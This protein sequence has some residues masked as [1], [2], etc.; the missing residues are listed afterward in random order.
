M[1]TAGHLMIMPIVLPLAAGAVL[2]LLDERR[3]VVKAVIS[4]VSALALVV[5]AI[6]L[7]RSV[8]NAFASSATTGVYLL[9]NWPAP[10]GIVLVLDRLSALMLVLTSVLALA[11]LAFSLARWHKAGPHFHTLFQFLLM[12]LN[13]AFL[14]GDLFN[15]FV[16]FEVLLAASYGLVLHGSGPLRVKAGLHYIAVNLAASSL[17]LIGV[18]L[19]YGVTGT[20]NMADLAQ[21]IPA[22]P[23][24]DRMLLEAGAAVL[25]VAFLVK[26]GMWPLSFW[27]P[28][29]YSAAAA[30]VA[31]IFVIMTKVGFYILLRLS[32]LLF[33][34][35]AGATAGFGDSWLLFGG[36]A[37]IAFGAIGVLAS[38]AVGRLAGFS[39]LVSS[40]TLLAAIGMADAR[41]TAGALFYMVSST[42]TIGAFFLLIELVERVQDPAAHVLSVTM[43]A[44]RDDMEEPVPE[45][46]EVGVA[47]PGTLAVLGICFAACGLLLAGLPPLSGF[48]GKFALLTAMVRPD[49]VAGGG[50][51]AGSTWILVALLI[52]S[53][54]CALIATMRAGIQIFWAPIEGT[55][56]RVLLLEIAPV[57]FLLTLCLLMTVQGGPM[58]RYMDATAQSLH[59]P[60]DYLRDV[61]STQPIPGPN[62]PRDK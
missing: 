22:V 15:L 25:G 45:Q 31:A 10:F 23:A 58:M 38:Q 55:V 9:G 62:A 30:P 44:Y 18:S 20:L 17:F 28:G 13:G 14:T 8:D 40:G 5:I 32:L 52:L 12:G 48:V 60:A 4:I 24:A 27:L 1:E 33:G 51:I 35:D 29:A 2:L 3:H 53:G 19:I 43:E 42:L 36:M 49:P 37:T 11:S 34:V 41:V 39:I 47:I 57:A 46:E 61:L 6:A 26:A 7:L 59:S 16:F 56:P 50:L 54:L 21:R